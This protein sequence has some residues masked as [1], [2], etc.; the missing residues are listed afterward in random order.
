MGGREIGMMQRLRRSWKRVGSP[1]TVLVAYSGGADSLSLLT[2]MRHLATVEKVTV[3][4]IHVDHGMRPESATDAVLVQ[5]NADH[6]NVPLIVRRI[7]DG[8]IA[9][10]DGVGPEEAMRRERY[11]ILAEIASAQGVSMVAVAHHQGDQAETVLLHLIR[12]SGMRGA[13]GIRPVSRLTVPWWEDQPGA[14]LTIWR[15]LLEESASSVGE[16]AAALRL[17]IVEDPSNHDP[18]YRRNAIRHQV[19]PLLDQ[20]APGVEATLA[21]F[22]ALAAEDG[23]ELDR[24]AA[25]TLRTLSASGDLPRLEWVTLPPAIRSRVLRLWLAGS[26][27]LGVELST[28]RLS[29]IL[30]VALVT[31]PVRQIQLGAGW[32]VEVSRKWLRL[33]SDGPL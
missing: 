11:R 5:A 26:L 17:P 13:S 7:S 12:G 3:T 6:L 28:N 25:D 15:P 22:A 30:D 23:D 18:V 29:A 33:R 10:H 16:H 20:I 1:A 14:E 9:V 32:S 4:A 19:L 2:L 24:Q 8:A 27:P 21:R 31:G